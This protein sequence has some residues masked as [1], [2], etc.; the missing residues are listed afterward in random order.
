VHPEVLLQVGLDG[1]LPAAEGA[2]ER[3]GAF[4]QNLKQVGYATLQK[5]TGHCSGI[6]FINL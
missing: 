3:L 5:R 4:V 6:D 2:H 1:E